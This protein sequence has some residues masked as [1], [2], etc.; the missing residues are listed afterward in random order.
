MEGY[1]FKNPTKQNGIILVSYV[2]LVHLFYPHTSVAC[3]YIYL[4]KRT[5]TQLIIEVNFQEG[6]WNRKDL[7]LV[8]I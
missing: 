3:T 1:H 4:G 7:V 2:G 6:L 5:H 8:Y